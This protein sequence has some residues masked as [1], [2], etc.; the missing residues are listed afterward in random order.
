M[1][2]WPRNFWGGAMLKDDGF[3]CYGALLHCAV[4]ALVRR[5]VVVYIGKSKFLT[6]RI[7]EH[8]RKRGKTPAKKLLYGTSE[9]KGMMFD[10]IWVRPCMLG[11]LDHLEVQMIR[12]YQ[13][14]YNVQHREVPPALDLSELLKAIIPMRGPPVEAPIRRRV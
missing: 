10:D 2:Q 8:I 14:K 7:H 4:Y 1:S 6:T 5:G 12:K 11:E 13:P 9:Y 3:V